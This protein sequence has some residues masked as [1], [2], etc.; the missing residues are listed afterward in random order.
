MT[1]LVIETEQRRLC[2][3]WQAPYE[4]TAWDLRLGIS[5]DFGHTLPLHGLHEKPAGGTSG[6]YLWSGNRELAAVPV[7]EL[8]AL[9]A[10]HLKESHPEILR[11]LGL[12]PGWRFLAAP[13]HED[14][15]FDDRLLSSS[16]ESS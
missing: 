3:R 13:G 10:V 1:D 11:F 8:H 9:H 6:W 5:A 16:G 7:G 12:P 4:P 14:V 15:W 2:E